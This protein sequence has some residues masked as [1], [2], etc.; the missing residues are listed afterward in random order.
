MK[1][2]RYVDLVATT[3]LHL[4]IVEP[5]SIE[6]QGFGCGVLAV[7]RDR[8][9]LLSVAHVTDLVGMQTAIET[10]QPVEGGSKL[11]GME[12]MCY[13]HEYPVPE[14][15]SAGQAI[16]IE[17]LLAEP[18]QRMDITFGELKE[19]VELLQPEWDFEAFRIEAGRKNMVYLDQI[20]TTELSYDRE[21]NFIGRVRQKIEG[22]ELRSQVTS[23][24]GMKYHGTEG[25]FHRFLVANIIWDAD[26]Y[27]GCSGAPIYDDLGNLVGLACMVRRNTKRLY[28]FPI[29]ECIRLLDIAIA[30]KMV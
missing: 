22:K 13:F 17:K 21:Y 4:V 29:E 19:N 16:D 27:R 14:T 18:G 20:A 11:Y 28:A 24:F 23:Q 25:L 3:T 5:G 12:S 1:E 10:N 2:I 30:T 7:Y 6:P 15:L 26:D 9:F 8:V